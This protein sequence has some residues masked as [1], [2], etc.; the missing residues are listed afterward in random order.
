MGPLEELGRRGITLQTR[1]I[2]PGTKPPALTRDHHRAKIRLYRQLSNCRDN[3]VEH[4]RIECVDFI[5]S[6]QGYVGNMIR[7]GD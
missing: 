1:H 5:R 2:K 7:S 3:G 4:G 6:G